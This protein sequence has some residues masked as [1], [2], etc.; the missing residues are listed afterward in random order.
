MPLPPGPTEPTFVTTY[1]WLTR[2]FEF[3]EDCAERYGEAFHLKLPQLPDLVVFSHPDVTK[4]VFADAGDTLLAGAFNRSLSAFLG[5]KSVLMVDGTDHLR[6]RKLLLPP[7]H[8]ERMHAYGQVMMDLADEAIDAFPFGEPFA[9]HERMNGI[10]LNVIVR[11]VIG[12][13]PGP[14]EIEMRRIM[15]ELLHLMTWPPLLVPAFRVDLGPFSPWGRALRKQKQADAMLFAEIGARRAR[16]TAGQED[17]LSL[18]LTA[19]DEEGRPMTD[20]ELRD[21]LVTL[22]VAGH[23]TTATALT[24]ALRW[25]LATPGVLERLRAEIADVGELTPQR[26]QALPY[27]DATVREALRLCPVIPIVGRVLAEDATVG[28]WDLPKGTAVICSIY[29]THRRPDVFEDP[30]RFWP[31][32]FLGKKVTPSEFYPFGGGIRRCIGMAFALFEMKMVLACLLRRV[33]IELD[34]TA[35]IRPVRRSITL[36]PSEGLRVRVVEKRP[37]G[38]SRAA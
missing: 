38:S 36:M 11:N 22:L 32:R 18:L 28:G 5:D 6:K 37:R 3:L 12:V 15:T 10:A 24:W 4:A 13:A 34:P 23:E 20:A 8:G 1:K 7:F 29:L 33:R 9:F 35:P 21:E 14:K 2:P 25:I 17:V 27:L 16:D 30:T 31:D 19:R 26:V